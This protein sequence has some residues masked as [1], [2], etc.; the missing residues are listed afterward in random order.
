MN[1]HKVTAKNIKTGE[2]LEF[3]TVKDCAAYFE[4]TRQYIAHKITSGMPFLK[5]WVFDY[6]C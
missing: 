4:T 5:W 2:A 1:R 6:A 3:E